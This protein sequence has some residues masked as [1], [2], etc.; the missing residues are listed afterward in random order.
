MS[1][2]VGESARAAASSLCGRPPSQ[3]GSRGQWPVL[4][5]RSFPHPWGCQ[6]S[7]HEAF[8]GQMLTKLS[9]GDIST[10]WEEPCLLG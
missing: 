2:Q 1:K 8:V 5:F 4:S 7:R 10:N 3:Q 6:W 9:Q